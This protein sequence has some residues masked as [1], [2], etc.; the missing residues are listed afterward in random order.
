MTREE[1]I[2]ALRDWKRYPNSLGSESCAATLVAD[3]AT[4]LGEEIP[5][6]VNA[7]L[8]ELAIRGTLR[9]LAMEFGGSTDDA[10][11]A[12]MSELVKSR[13]LGM[14]MTSGAWGP[15]LATITRYV[16]RVLSSA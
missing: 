14:S 5:A 3:V 9:D 15:A 11:V 16:N 10:A 12:A 13:G 1:V 2:K 8:A 6:E 7:A 4:V